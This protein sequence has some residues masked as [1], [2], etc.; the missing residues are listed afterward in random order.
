MKKLVTILLSISLI[1]FFAFGLTACFDDTTGKTPAQTLPG[2]ATTGEKMALAS[3]KNYLS[4]K[5]FSREGLIEQLK[6]EGYSTDEATYAVD[7]CGADW[8]EQAAKA[9][10][11]YLELLPMSE[12]QLIDQLKFEGFT[13]E[14]AIYG[15]EQAYNQ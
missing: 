12:Q 15:A 4:I 13:E 2:N 5:A 6:F 9:A 7:N 14:E 10:K 3:A 1:F 8:K 11:E